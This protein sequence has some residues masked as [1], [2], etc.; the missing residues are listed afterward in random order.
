MNNNKDSLLDTLKKD[1][2]VKKVPLKEK[3]KVDEDTFNALNY[4]NK[5]GLPIETIIEEAISTWRKKGVVKIAKDIQK[6][7][8]NSNQ[9]SQVN[10]DVL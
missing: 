7:E 9:N 2:V 10:Q 5:K 4:L 8:E 1:L 3:I 6:E